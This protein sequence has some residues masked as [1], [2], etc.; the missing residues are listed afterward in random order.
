MVDPSRIVLHFMCKTIARLMEPIP[1]QKAKK[2]AAL[3]T[4]TLTFRLSKRLRS[5][6]DVAARSKGVKLANFVETALEGSLHDPNKFLKGSSIA[7]KADLLY[8]EDDALCFIKRLKFP[9]A[10]NS[11]QKRLLDL[12]RTSRLLYPSWGQYDEEL[13]EEHWMEL[14]GIAE[15]RDDARALPPEFFDGVD[16]EFALMCDAE[17]IALYRKDPVGCTNRTQEYVERT[18]RPS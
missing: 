10:M 13:I 12:I 15:G 17:R 11:E 9:W 2:A 18:K 7:A 6:A 8:D 4:E 14:Q 16:I 3:R 5:L 1:Q